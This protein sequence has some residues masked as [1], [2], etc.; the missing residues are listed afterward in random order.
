MQGRPPHE[1]HGSELDAAS[2]DADLH[3]ATHLKAMFSVLRVEATEKV[4]NHEAYLVIG[5]REG[6]APRGFRPDTK[7]PHFYN[8]SNNSP[9]VL[10]KTQSDQKDYP[11]AEI[12][13][14]L[15]PGTQ[16]KTGDKLL[17]VEAMKTFNEILAPRAGMVTGILVDDGQPVEY[18]QPLLVIE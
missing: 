3:F 10:E 12:R 14:I 16:V 8:L 4:E 17:L 15:P 6:K 18:G 7:M 13:A 1:M 2:M 5:H 11:A 9:E